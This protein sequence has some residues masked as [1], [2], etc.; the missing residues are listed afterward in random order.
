MISSTGNR[1]DTIRKKLKELNEKRKRFWKPVAGENPI[2]ML[3]WGD[4]ETFYFEG[5][6]H[7]FPWG[8]QTGRGTVHTCLEL[9]NK[10]CPG[11][12]KA[13]EL[14]S[15]EDVED[16]SMS[17]RI[18]AKSVYFMNLV[19]LNHPEHGVQVW[20][21]YSDKVMTDML[22]AWADPDCGD[23]THP[24]RG[25]N[26]VII[27]TD[28]GKAPP[29][30]DAKVKHTATRIQNKRW[31]RKVKNLRKFI[32]LPNAQ[33]MRAA[34]G[35]TPTS[36]GATRRDDEDTERS[37]RSEKY[38]CFGKSYKKPRAY[39]REKYGVRGLP[40]CI[41]CPVRR[42]CKMVWRERRLQRSKVGASERRRRR[43]RG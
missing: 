27:V 15:S 28:R 22:T 7:Y 35:M 31:L 36:S 5:K 11:C 33:E 18:Q 24:R 3:P 29:L 20:R 38:P 40:I 4:N 10:P 32:S 12:E 25:K 23:F 37:S 41:E 8:G 14:A 1:L 19:D 2:R 6:Q 17:E 16:V 43:L 42:R 34:L 13:E 9:T 26:V 30:Y 39:R 21:T